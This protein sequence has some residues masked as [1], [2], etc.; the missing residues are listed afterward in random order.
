[1]LGVF[2]CTQVQ[3]DLA[4]RPCSIDQI[5]GS[6]RGMF[7]GPPVGKIHS[8]MR[9]G[10]WPDRIWT[11]IVSFSC[12]LYMDIPCQSHMVYDVRHDDVRSISV[13]KNSRINSYEFNFT[14][15]VY[16]MEE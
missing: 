15:I 3:C 12:G 7:Q 6:E 14:N 5:C 16:I 2:Y 4:A 10:K 13:S 8:L 9:Y 1:M 11:Y